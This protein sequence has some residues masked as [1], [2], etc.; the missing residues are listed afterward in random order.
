RAG[1]VV[2]PLHDPIRVAEEWAVVDQLSQGRVGISFASGWHD[3][4]FV[5][6]PEAYRDRKKI[7]NR[8]LEQVCALWR[9]EKLTRLSGSGKD[10]EVRIFPRPVQQELP[11][12]IT[13]A[14]NPDAFRIAG[15]LGANVLT[16]LLGQSLEDLEQKIASYREAIQKSKKGGMGHVTLMLH[17]FVAESQEDVER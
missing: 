15:E 13:I 1:S 10:V 17:T 7:M 12:W 8:Q 9:G 16:H 14:G 6:A 5:L 3:R 2:L 4:D 11:V